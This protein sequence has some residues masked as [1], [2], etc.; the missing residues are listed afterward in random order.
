MKMTNYLK[1]KRLKITVDTC[2]LFGE[3]E[4]MAM[5]PNG[6]DLACIRTADAQSATEAHISI[7]RSYMAQELLRIVD[8][9]TEAQR[10]AQ[11]R[12]VGTEDGG[13][14]NFDAPALFLPDLQPYEVEA[15]ATAAQCHVF[16]WETSKKRPHYRY[17]VF[18][19][20]YNSGQGNRNTRMAETM[21]DVLRD[22][23]YDST[24]YYQID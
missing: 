21:A 19:T 8:A 23:G 12:H 2:Q 4:T 15:I 1:H 5:L 13:T 9:I 24:V 20:P 3:Y 6:D 14:C 18:S 7:L 10:V 16:Q 22:L 17:F 11:E